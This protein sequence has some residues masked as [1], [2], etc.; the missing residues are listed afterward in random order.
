M[1]SYR[2][3]YAEYD[4]SHYGSRLEG[5]ALFA[6]RHIPSSPATSSF[7]FPLPVVPAASG[8][9]RGR[10]IYESAVPVPLLR[11]VRPVVVPVAARFESSQPTAITVLGISTCSLQQ[12]RPVALTDHPTSNMVLRSFTLFLPLCLSLY[13]ASFCSII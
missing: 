7:P 3:S 13:L 10:H 6:R 2:S 12:R 11:R 5:P 1:N 9:V 4:V 8:L